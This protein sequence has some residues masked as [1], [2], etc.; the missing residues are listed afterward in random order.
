[1]GLAVLA[2]ALDHLGDEAADLAELA[3]AKAACRP[4]R[5][6]QADARRDERLF[7]IERNAVLVARDRGPIE[8]LLGMLPLRLLGPQVDE[9]EVVVR[10]ARNDVEAGV[11]KGSCKRAGV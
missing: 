8:R 6:P 4:R 11:L 2:Q 10:A 5:R 3:V 9:H 7:G 1:A